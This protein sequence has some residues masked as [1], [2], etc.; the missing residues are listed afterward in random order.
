MEFISLKPLFWLGALA[1][2]FVVLR[3][4][5]VDRPRLRMLSSFALR[6]LSIVL[7]ILAMCRPFVGIE[8]DQQHIVF[9]VDVSESI[10]ISSAKEAVGDIEKGISEL[11]S[12]D[13]WSL[14]AIG[15]EIRP[16]ETPA[17]LLEMLDKWD[18]GIRDDI[19]RS[20]SAIAKAILTS[21]LS[22][23]AG[24][25]RRIVIYSDG[26]ETEGDLEKA[27]RI[28]NDEN[29]DVRI[30][31][32]EKLK[33]PEA[34]VNSLSASSI[35]A[36]QGQVVRMTAAMVCNTTMKGKLRILHKGAVVEQADVELNPDNDNTVLLDVPM[37]TPGASVW[38][39]ELVAEDDY[40]PIN[41]QQS[42][43]VTVRGKPRLLILHQKP[44]EIRAISRALKEQEF[45]IET[46]GI[47]GLGETME[48]LLEF[49]AI[50]LADIAAT[51]ISPRQMELV[52]RYVIDFG[53]GLIMMGSDNSF[54]LGGYYKTP[55]EEVIPLISRYE[56][57]KEKP[58][59]AM[60]LVIDKSGSMS[61]MKIQ[62]ARQAAKATVE[63]LS[64]QDK[65][66]VVGFDGRAFIV[67]EMTSAA[68][69]DTVKDAIDT[70]AAGGGTY[71]YPGMQTAMQML[72]MT[73]AKVKHVIVLGD[74]QSQ[75]A[76]HE[77]LAA[78]MSDMGIT[79]STVALGQG[80]DRGLMAS[81]AEIG[82]GRYYE[83]MDPTSVPQIFTRETMQ[84]SRSAIKEDIFMTIQTGDH[85]FMAGFNED[86]LPF[87]LGYVM[88][89]PKPTSQV[90]LA[91]ETGDPLLAISR[92]GLGVGMAYTSDLTEKWGGEWLA[93]DGGAKFWSQA[94]R[95]I[96][97]KAD[98]EGMQTHQQ[99]VNGKWQI[100]I[101]RRDENSMPVSAIKWD[102][103]Y[104]DANGAMTGLG[105]K[106]VGLGR[107]KVEVDVRN[108]KKMSLRLHDQDHDKLAVLHYHQAYPA[109]YNLSNKP[110][111]GFEVLDR[112]TSKTI[113]GGAEPARHKKPVSH[114]AYLLS[115]A[116]M[117]GGILL[118]RI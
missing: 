15:S 50:I 25:A 6:S 67:C 16:I 8:N 18:E 19:F 55:I 69:G 31:K 81:I 17:L 63:L 70:L 27:L 65:I 71:M 60:A 42:C 74:G 78:E 45:E 105:V 97:R 4:S 36:F 12:D 116:S 46:R 106:Q 90:L 91:A 76:D 68:S 96:V 83:T 29:I 58:S 22:F 73:S 108:E 79:V 30:S 107:Y 110:N 51:D 59:L 54:G 13:S 85:P 92:Y 48:Q 9:L 57:E 52:K 64:P 11:K 102:C 62:L 115:L 111:Q 49:D 7:L 88:T 113:R 34:S 28:V 24:K 38:T 80:A 41:N 26:E 93:W 94:I 86:E 35:S 37:N 104:L 43:T 32:L 109:E 10:D 117:M 95:C 56:K 44:Q 72:E 75:P 89:E 47:Y 20:K 53:G 99:L 100:N 114:W 23:P 87:T 101:V 84:A 5:L 98:V 77:G 82:R 61:G 112:F 33:Y 40:F 39:A 66:G 103:R 21:R 2:L 3:Y 14:F 1:A 118:R